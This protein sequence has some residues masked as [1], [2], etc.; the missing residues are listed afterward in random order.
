MKF[1][2]QEH[3]VPNIIIVNVTQLIL[4]QEMCCDS[5]FKRKFKIQ[6]S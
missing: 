3:F 5:D 6:I 2:S 1:K 4:C